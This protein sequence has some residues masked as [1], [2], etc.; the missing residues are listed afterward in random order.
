MSMSSGLWMPAAVNILSA[1]EA[2][3]VLDYTMAVVPLMAIFSS[4]VFATLADRKYDSKSLLAVLATSGSV[5]LW[6]A[7]ACLEWGW[8]PWWYLFFHGCNALISGPQWVLVTK[9][10]LVHARNKQRDFPLFRIWAT[11]GWIVAG[12]LVSWLAWDSS[13]A[14][15]KLA[16]LAKLLTGIT[17]LM[18]PRTPP[19][20]NEGTKKS[21]IKEKLGL[22]ALVLF[23][24]RMLK[25]YFITTL[26]LTIPLA[27]FYLYTPKLLME[28]SALDQSDFAIMVQ[29]WL[30]GPS[31]QMTLG[32]MT[33]IGAMLLMSYL[34]VRARLRVLVIIAMVLAVLRFA[35]F[36]LAG[37][38]EILALMWL[39]VALHGPV[40]TFFSITG[41]MFVD[42]RVPEDMRAQ[43]QALLSLMTAFGN[44]LG[45]LAVGRFYKSTVGQ[46]NIN[47]QVQSG[48][49]LFWW[50]LTI[51]VV[52]SLVYFMIGYRE[53]QIRGE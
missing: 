49:P 50:V 10:A 47:T 8:S 45:P 6:L 12:I 44:I 48:W 37:E 46:I 33:E 39:G 51:A 29:Q 9:V 22:G 32:Q 24:N 11:V 31:A 34:G 18:L 14:T 36:A 1:Y 5:F 19:A 41:Q 27:A 28:L 4:M 15:G 17:A 52:C 13:V 40:Y 7:F 23:E 25:V 30:P 35:L 21:T 43:A 3:W 53:K 2:Q 26:I 16:A 20:V 38:H 42:R